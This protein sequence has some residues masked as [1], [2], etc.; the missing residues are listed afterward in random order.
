MAEMGFD[1][2]IVAGLDSANKMERFRKEVW[3]LL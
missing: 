2:L 3:P 1:Q